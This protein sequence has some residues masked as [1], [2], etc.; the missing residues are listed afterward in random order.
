EAEAW[1]HGRIRAAANLLAPRMHSSA[2]T[3][4][5]MQR[6]IAG[7]WHKLVRHTAEGLPTSLQQDWRLLDDMAAGRVSGFAAG[8]PL[9][10][11]PTYSSAVELPPPAPQLPSKKTQQQQQEKEQQQQQQ[12]AEEKEATHG[13]AASTDDSNDNA[14]GTR[15]SGGV[16]ASNTPR[17]GSASSPAGPSSVPSASPPAPT[18]PAPPP[19]PQSAAGRSS[20]WS[21][22]GGR[23]GRRV[24]RLY[25][26]V[27]AR[28]EYKEVLAVA[29]ALLL[30]Y[31]R[32]Y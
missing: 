18:A 1:L 7:L 20:L 32:N 21:A 25:A 5:A 6:I 15:S 10:L 3:T 13:P 26:A 19:P 31:A 30:Q 27:R 2:P 29:E 12:G 14:S 9:G 23:S 16:Q 11:D 22:S 4:P 8:L 28:V 17:E 24:G